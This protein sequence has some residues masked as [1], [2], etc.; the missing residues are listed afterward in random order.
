MQVMLLLK[1][2]KRGRHLIKSLHADLPAHGFVPMDELNVI[3]SAC[4]TLKGPAIPVPDALRVHMAVGVV[5]DGVHWHCDVGYG[6][7]GL[8]LPIR[9]DLV[10]TSKD[11]KFASG[12]LRW[13]SLPLWAPVK[14]S[15]HFT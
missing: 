15:S 4:R 12:L 10:Q 1:S 2:C 7:K 11:G 6:G 9:N 3:H 14:D 13:L 8:R 5:L